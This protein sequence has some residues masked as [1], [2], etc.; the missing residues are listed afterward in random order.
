VARYNK[1]PTIALSFPS[2]GPL[3]LPNKQSAG[4]ISPFSSYGPTFDLLS[5]PSLA[6]PGDRILSTWPVSSGSWAILSGTSMACPHVA[7]A[8]ALLLQAARE[9]RWIAGAPT[10][11][12]PNLDV[13]DV[14]RII[15][16]LR[17]T[18]QPGSN[19]TRAAMLETGAKQGSGLLQVADAVRFNT[20]VSCSLAPRDALADCCRMQVSPGSLVLDPDA[21]FPMR[22][23][24][25]VSNSGTRA[26][27]F[28][29]LHEP[30]GT[31]LTYSAVSCDCWACTTVCC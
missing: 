4:V 3:S 20:S 28:Q 16:R 12:S 10:H 31:A 11:A 18:A 24:F 26:R 6:A 8:A 7:A 17:S 22:R 14:R 23:S 2:T 25:T 5:S 9:K 13:M 27:T 21:A 19:S 15:D 1:D 30:A 29:I